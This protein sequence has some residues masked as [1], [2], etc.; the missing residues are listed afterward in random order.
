MS[1]FAPPQPIGTEVFATIP[2]QHR[3]AT[4]SPER[5]AAGKP[6]ADCFI[7]GP[8]FDRDGNLWLVDI[9]YGRVFRVSP[10]GAVDCVA[11]YDGEPNGLKIHRDGRIFI[12]D[13]KQGILLLDAASGAVTPLVTRYKGERFRG[14]NDLFFAK[15]GDLYFT[16]QGQSG[17]DAP[18]GRVYRLSAAGRLEV[19][20]DGIPSPNGIVLD[21]AE[22][23]IYTAVT[24]MNCVW[25]SMI[26]PDGSTTRTGVWVYLGGGR[27]PD[28]MAMAEDGSLAVAHPGMGAVWIFSPRGE[29]LY[30][31]QSCRGDFV[32]NVAFG[33][34]D[35]RQLFITESHTGTVLVAQ[36]P[37]AGECMYSHR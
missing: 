33:G 37:M 16:D 9:P 17:M 18:Y 6:H 2:P 1:L 32:T 31:V 27:G 25:Q 23:H 3:R 4:P 29:P 20:V 5:L 36:V 24:R 21:P 35:R 30:R 26:V 22:K 7:E 19:V 28:G 13:H 10:A 34:P 8:S 11:E 15:N 14:P 12:A